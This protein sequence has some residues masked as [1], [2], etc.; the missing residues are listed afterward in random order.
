MYSLQKKAAHPNILAFHQP[1]EIYRPGCDDTWMVDADDLGEFVNDWKPTYRYLNRFT[2]PDGGI[3]EDATD[4]TTTYKI[5]ALD[6]EEWLTKADGTITV[7]GSLVPDLRGSYTALYEGT[8]DEELQTRR[9][10]QRATTTRPG[11]L[12][13][14]WPPS[15]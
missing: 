6:G 4:A 15:F 14:S 5:K 8:K 13:D 10:S 3:L 9:M 1:A 11:I 12:F 7:G 2:I